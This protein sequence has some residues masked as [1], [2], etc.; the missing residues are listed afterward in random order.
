M[1]AA[2]NIERFNQYAAHFLAKLYNAFPQPCTLDC[3]E[4]ITGKPLPDPVSQDQLQAATVDPEVRFCCDALRWLHTTGY[5][6]GDERLH[7]V[8]IARAVLTPKGFEA[9]N[10]IPGSLQP[11][12]GQQLTNLASESA[13]EGARVAIGEVIGQIIGV[14][15]RHWFSP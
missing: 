8:Q 10:A 13:K 2:S 14:A 1:T 11:P 7:T 12:L 4:A 3:V 5:F 9:L 6:T 15:T